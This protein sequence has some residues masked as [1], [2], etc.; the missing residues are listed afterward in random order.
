MNKKIALFTFVSSILPTVAFAAT[1]KTLAS[2]ID[3]IITYAN[4]ILVLMMGIA[5]VMFV[6]HVIKYFIMADAERK[7]AGPYV[8]WSLIGFFVILSMWGLVNILQNTF[9]LQNDTNRPA[10]WNSFTNI[11]PGGGSSPTSNGSL[12]QVPLSNGS[13]N[14][15]PR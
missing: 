1:N 15:V 9:G 8:M 10:G 13:L 12:N 2:L 5:V 14:Q 6:Y 4:R 11:F 3:L 7:E